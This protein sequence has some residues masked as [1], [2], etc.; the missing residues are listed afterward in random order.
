M[1]SLFTLLSEVK[2]YKNPINVEIFLSPPISI[3]SLSLSFLPIIDH[4]RRIFKTKNRATKNFQT[5]F[6]LHDSWKERREEKKQQKCIWY[7][8]E[9]NFIKKVSFSTSVLLPSQCRMS[10]EWKNERKKFMKFEEA[11]TFSTFP[12]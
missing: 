7:W 12:S 5:D 1:S 6:F 9:L 11:T 10:W 2:S 4:S 8:W 3:E